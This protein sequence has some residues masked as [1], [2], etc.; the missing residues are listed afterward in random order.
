[1]KFKRLLRNFAFTAGAL[2]TLALIFIALAAPLLAPFDPFHQDTIRRL[3]APSRERGVALV[4]GAKPRGPELPAC[5]GGLAGRLCHC[6]A[7]SVSAF[8]PEEDQSMARA[9]A[10]GDRLTGG[11][12]DRRPAEA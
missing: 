12:D 7:A 8:R 10:A 1:M 9:R 3:E 2:L 11:L 5:D 6:D 4:R